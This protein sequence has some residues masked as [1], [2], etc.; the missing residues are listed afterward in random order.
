M[1]PPQNDILNISYPQSYTRIFDS[2]NILTGCTAE[3]CVRIIDGLRGQTDRIRMGTPDAF[4]VGEEERLLALTIPQ[5]VSTVTSMYAC[6]WILSRFNPDFISEPLLDVMKLTT[7]TFACGQQ[8][9]RDLITGLNT[10]IAR[11]DQTITVL[12][13]NVVGMDGRLEDAG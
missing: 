10:V 13:Q 2:I 1:P 5:L 6:A 7:V 8:E 11:L 9:L 3:R 4:D 12:N